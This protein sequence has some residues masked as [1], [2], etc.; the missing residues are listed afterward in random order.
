M[1]ALRVLS[2]SAD[3]QHAADTLCLTH[4]QRHVRRKLLT[5]TSGQEVLLDLPHAVA[6]EQGDCL[7]LENGAL[8][9]VQAADEELIEITAQ[10]RAHLQQLCWHLGNRH[11]PTQI[12]ETKLFIKRDHVIQDMLTG[13]GAT[14]RD[15]VGPF[16]PVRGAYH[17]TAQYHSHDHD[18]SHG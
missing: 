16:S 1:R 13:L 11:L 10:S 17:A 2:S 7:E 6:L 8:V 5:T 4:N 3:P 9:Q 15:I 12:D 18:H 14:T